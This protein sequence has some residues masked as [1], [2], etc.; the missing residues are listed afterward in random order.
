MGETFVPWLLFIAYVLTI[1]GLTWWNRRKALTMSD[2]A[3]GSRSVPPFFVGLSL[4][5]NMTSVAT[6]VINPGLVHAYG[7]AGVMGYG[8]A[9]PLGAD[10]RWRSAAQRRFRAQLQRTAAPSARR[11]DRGE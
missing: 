1:I 3:V 7:W 10:R 11:R 9:A 4:A 6:F 2:F 5:A 8:I